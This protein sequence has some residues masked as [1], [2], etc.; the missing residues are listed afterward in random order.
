MF[1]VLLVVGFLSLAFWY[2]FLVH[3]S[4]DDGLPPGPRFRLPLIG[5]ALHLGKNPTV[6]LRKLRKQ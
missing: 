5:Q 4:E 6:G 3:R 2:F 1:F